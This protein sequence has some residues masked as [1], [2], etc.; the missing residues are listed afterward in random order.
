MEFLNKAVEL[1]NKITDTVTDFSSDEVIVKT[2][3]KSVEKLG[4]ESCVS[5]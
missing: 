2:I 3:I 1:G 5:V 4:A